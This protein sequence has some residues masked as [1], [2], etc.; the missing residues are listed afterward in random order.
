MEG[1]CSFKSSVGGVCGSDT[2]DRKCHSAIIPL[3]S[4]NKDISI[5]KFSVHF[6]EREDAVDHILC[7]T[8]WF[9]TRE[10]LSELTICL[11]HCGKL[12]LGW[13][14]RASTRCRVLDS[15]ISKHGKGKAYG[16]KAIEC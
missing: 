8:A 5:Y 2:Q 6:S 16:L 10:R 11:N 15:T 1:C 12:G 13:S 9:T 14:R 7:R 3:I 4:C